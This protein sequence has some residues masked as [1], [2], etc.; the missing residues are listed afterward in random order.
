MLEEPHLDEARLALDADLG[1]ALAARMRALV[2]SRDAEAIA[3]R[4]LV[5]AARSR[6]E[7]EAL[8]ALWGRIEASSRPPLMVSTHTAALAADRYGRGFDVAPDSEAA[9]RGAEAGRPALIELEGRAW[10]GKLLVRPS[11]A[12]V[13][14]LPDDPHGRPTAL[15][16]A[17][18]PPGPTGEDR[19]FWVTD[20]AEATPVI[21]DALARAGLPG[22]LL[23]AGGGLKLFML[24]G[25]VQREDGRLA[26]LPGDLAGVIGAAPTF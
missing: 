10:W 1:L 7:G 19:S 21:E 26:G 23:H 4:R 8:K 24:A 6:A 16:I 22:R 20:S 14:A 3:L 15:M 17:S 12:V 9:L 25:Y 11:L 5:R 18:E 13:A 2:L